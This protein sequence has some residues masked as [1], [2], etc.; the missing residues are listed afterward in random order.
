MVLLP[1]EIVRVAD[2][3]DEQSTDN[4]VALA[5]FTGRLSI[6]GATLFGCAGLSSS[7]DSFSVLSFALSAFSVFAAVSDSSPEVTVLLAA[8]SAGGMPYFFRNG[9]SFKSFFA[10]P[11]ILGFWLKARR[12]KVEFA[13]SNFLA[14]SRA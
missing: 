2:G 10:A 12:S 4:S 5:N 13:S 6:S 3:E 1:C 11:E 8:F 7:S 9:K 14:A